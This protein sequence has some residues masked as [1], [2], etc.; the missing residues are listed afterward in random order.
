[1]SNTAAKAHKW[2][3]IKPSED[4]ALALA[5]AHV[6]LTRGMWFKDFVGDFADG[7]NH[8]VAGQEVGAE[9]FVEK[10]TNGLARWWNIELKDK[11][12]N[13]RR[14]CAVFL[15]RRSSRW[16]PVC[17]RRPQLRRLVRADHAAAGQLCHSLH[18]RP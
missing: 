2:L 18:A 6:I 1:M 13:G 8:F 10:H 16:Q 15:P 17:R 5:M 4:G 11:T 9:D 14:P 12:P 3:P 7:N